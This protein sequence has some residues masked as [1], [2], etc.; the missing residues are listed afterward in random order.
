VFDGHPGPPQIVETLRDDGDAAASLSTIAER[1][2]KRHVR[3]D[4]RSQSAG[5]PASRTNDGTLRKLTPVHAR[6]FA[7][8]TWADAWIDPAGASSTSRP[9]VAY[10]EPR[11][12]AR[13]TTAIT[14]WPHIVL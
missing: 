3:A 4:T 7:R 12:M 11:S 2:A 13:V 5:T 10:D 6:P 1:A 8:L 14:P 9:A